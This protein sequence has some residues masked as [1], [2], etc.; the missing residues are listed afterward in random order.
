MKRT[1]ILYLLFAVLTC[2]MA[3]MADNYVIINQVMY[4]SPLNEQVQYTPYSNG[5]FIELY[6]GSDETVSLQGWYLSGGGATEKFYLTGLS[7]PSGGYLVVAF[8]HSDSPSFALSDVF[9]LP[10]DNPT[11]QVVYQNSLILANQGETITLYNE[12]QEIVDQMEYDGTSNTSKPNHLGADNGDDTAGD[13][14]RSLHRTW[15]EFD[16][17]G[18]VVPNISQWKTDRVSFGSC[19]LA[20]QNFGEHHLTGNQSLPDGENYII[21][22]SPLDHATRVSISDNGIS[23][24]NGVRTRTS[25]RYY[26]GLGRPVE[27]IALE[28]SPDKDDWVQVTGYSGLNRATKHWLPVPLQTEG[29]YADVADVQTEVQSYY[30]DNRPFTETLY[31]NSSLERITGHRQAG[32]SYFSHPSANTYSIN[33]ATDNVRIYTIVRDSVLKTTGES[34][35]ANTLFKTIVADEDEKAVATYTDKLGRKIAEERDGNKTYYVYDNLERLRFVL[36]HIQDNKL[37]NGE[38][39]LSNTI[40]QTAAYCYKYDERG[41][42]IYKRLPGCEPIYMVYD[43]TG[44]L[45]LKQD[46]NQRVENK[47]TL[48]AYDSIGRNLYTAEIKLTQPHE[49]YVDFYADKWA[50]EHY[51]NNPSNKSIPNTGYASTLLGKNNLK[52]LIINYYDDYDYI[53]KREQTFMRSQLRFSQESGYGLQYDNAIG[54]LTGTRIYNLSE[55]GCY[56]AYSYYYDVK[57]RV[58]Q[59]RSMQNN[60][61]GYYTAT[62]TEYLFDGSVA[63]QLTEQ[64]RENYLVREH[65]RYTYDHAGRAQNTF[66]QLNEDDEILLSAFSYDSI[67]RLVQNLLYNEQDTIRYSFD[68]R[69]M[70]TETRHKYYNEQLFYADNIN[71]GGI[72][73]C[74]NGNISA[75][76]EDG[77]LRGYGYDNMN[78]LTE[79]FA[80][81]ELFNYGIVKTPL[82]EFSYDEVGNLLSLKRGGYDDLTFYYG[83]DG[84]QLLSI[85]ENGQDADL[86]DVIEFTDR[87]S[88][89]D[90]PLLYDANGNL[91]KDAYRH[92]SRI[93]Y[94]ILNLPDTIQ[95]SNGHQIVNLYDASGRKYRTVNYTNLRTVNT[96]YNEIAYYTYDTD[97]VEYQVTEY[98]GNIMKIQTKEDSV[99]TDKQKIFNTTG[100]YTDGRYFH[101]VKNHL[102]SICLVLDSEADSIVQSTYYSASGV[103]FSNNLDEQPYLYNGKEFVEAHGWNTYDYGFRG[104]YAPIGR[105]TSIDP[106]AEQCPWQSPYA[107][108]GNNFVN[109]IDW[110]GL[111]N[112][113]FS[114]KYQS[115]WDEVIRKFMESFSRQLTILDSKGIVVSHIDNGDK[116]VKYNGETIG[117]ELD[118]EDYSEGRRVYFYSLKYNAIRKFYSIDVGINASRNTPWDERVR[119]WLRAKRVD[120]VEEKLLEY[121]QPIVQEMALIN[122][123]LGLYNNAKILLTGETLYN[124]KADDL[125]KKLA[126]VS[127]LTSG[128]GKLVPSEEVKYAAKHLGRGANALSSTHS[129]QKD[130]ESISKK[131]H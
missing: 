74:Y 121:E 125:D 63:Q 5:E 89:T 20:E 45:V 49:Y 109:N 22:V 38:Y 51:G 11:F 66:Y 82:E 29:Q 44:Q 94:N 10:I 76:V 67:G 7:I 110:M 37:N 131:N 107:Y 69:N 15:V 111:S 52:P 46:G 114:E 64:G 60:T 65:Y 75:I 12:Q 81:K 17:E 84:N 18:K 71:Q 112:L 113:S 80:F 123:I 95:F 2:S 42:M 79:E 58:I 35:A 34:F 39:E 68:I 126:I 50:V 128:V 47:W 6:N 119:R 3:C 30:S 90:N 98:V 14:C 105:F 36:P 27:T 43:K 118:D 72:T 55:D 127:V 28:T 108:A 83:N 41:N 120:K 31:E 124:Q 129:L 106:L 102:G 24:S 100:Y 57:G 59:N 23:V 8:R 32:E 117:L 99:L 4:D 97:S 19:R 40:L 9:T 25:V 87:A 104:Y 21:S 16:E 91:V 33:N 70:L 13:L 61:R 62:S 54:L 53:A 88:E 78:R 26:D 101:Y 56:T 93:K 77:S 115:E 92:I 86:Y 103:P 130:Y 122:P 116:S 48:C 96:D 73:P 85:T 1:N